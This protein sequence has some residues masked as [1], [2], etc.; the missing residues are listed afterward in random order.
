MATRFKLIVEICEDKRAIAKIKIIIP[1]KTISSLNLEGSSWRLPRVIPD[2]TP[3][4]SVLYQ[5]L[6]EGC[7]RT[8]VSRRVLLISI[9]LCNN[10]ALS[11]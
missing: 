4:R 10:I 3:F 7:Y 11:Y 9:S 6:P 1:N 2:I 8:W 5:L